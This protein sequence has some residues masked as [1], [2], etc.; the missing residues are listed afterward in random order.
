ML[1]VKITTKFDIPRFDFTKDLTYLAKRVLIPSMAEG[2]QKGISID[3]GAF[4]KLSPATIRMKRNRGLSTKILIATGKL[5]RAFIHAVRG[6]N[7]VV[8]T[9]K[10]DRKEIGSFLQIEGI[11]TR[12][13]RKFFKFFGVSD[14]AHNESIKYIKNRIRK[15]LRKYGR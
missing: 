8:V 2:I 15:L 6:M 1:K 10:S 9:L 12:S 14:K 11:K 3:G 5:H 4:P 7:Y 13:G